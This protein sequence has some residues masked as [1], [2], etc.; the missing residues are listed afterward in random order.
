M[1]YIF[2][3]EVT[4]TVEHTIFIINEVTDTI[5]KHYISTTKNNTTTDEI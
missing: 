5:L 1:Y 4:Y 2:N 3:F